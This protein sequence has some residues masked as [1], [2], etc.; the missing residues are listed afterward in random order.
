MRTHVADG[1]GKLIGDMQFSHDGRYLAVGHYEDPYLTV[2]E[3]TNWSKIAIPVLPVVR[4]ERLKFSLDD[5]LK[6]LQKNDN[7]S[8]LASRLLLV[9]IS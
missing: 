3:T 9:F 1:G 8:E 5:E 6:G 2:Y 4:V 7:T